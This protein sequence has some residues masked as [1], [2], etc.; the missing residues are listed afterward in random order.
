MV[1]TATTT[2]QMALADGHGDLDKGGLIKVF[3]R[4]LNVEFRRRGS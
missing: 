4:I 2:F 1:Q 3:E